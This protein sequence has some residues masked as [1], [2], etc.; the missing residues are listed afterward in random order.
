MKKSLIVSLVIILVAFLIFGVS[1]YFYIDANKPKVATADDIAASQQ[2]AS[3]DDI[4]EESVEKSAKM[5]S[6]WND[7]GI[8]CSNYNKAYQRVSNM[9]LEE[10]TGSI[11]MGVCEY[12]DESALTDITKY[13]LS[14]YL[15]ESSCFSGMDEA[16][17]K[18]MVQK[19][20]K[21]SE[22]FFLT[23]DEEGGRYTT[24]TDH[25][26]F[27]DFSFSSI[28]D[29]FREGGI[30]EVEKM[31]RD[32]L[33]ILKECGITLNLA[34]DLDLATEENHMMYDR[35]LGADVSVTTQYAEYVTKTYQDEGVSV[36]PKHF[37]G[38]GT[39]E[40]SY[41]MP[42][43]DTRLLKDIQEKDYLPF[44]AAIDNKC[45]FVMVSNLLVQ[46]MDP[47]NIASMSSKVHKALR[48]DLGFT[49][50]IITDNLNDTVSYGETVDYVKAVTAGNDMILVSN[51]GEAFDTILQAAQDGTITVDVLQKAATRV[52]AYKYS[53]GLLKDKKIG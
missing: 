31:E 10:L 42:V 12:D 35:S 44:K 29:V 46:S 11:I 30:S 51:Y 14:S 50:I 52:L 18:E 47:T 43:T 24:I 5:P 22:G 26:A 25:E 28:G 48:N 49:G 38:Y 34:P 36:C 39:V 15:M 9:S 23:V 16:G 41:E 8:F 19:Y 20:K 13:K 40:D 53:V 27:T 3:G 32:K 21:R 7:N 4:Q 33:S 1:L 37:P 17:I 45:H 6:D 2:D